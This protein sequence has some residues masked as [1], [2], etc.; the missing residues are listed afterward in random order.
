[1]PL[2]PV[3]LQVACLWFCRLP[4][5]PDSAFSFGFFF[6]LS[7]TFADNSQPGSCRSAIAVVR[8]P[9]ARPLV[10]SALRA[11]PPFILSF[12]PHARSARQA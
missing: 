11:I 3:S 6:V 5:V 8:P 12:S 2:F 9:P 7:P 4:D 10:S 1:M